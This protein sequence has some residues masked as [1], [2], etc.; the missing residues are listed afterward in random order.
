MPEETKGKPEARLPERNS[1]ILAA[2]SKLKFVL[3]AKGEL[4][5]LG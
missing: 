5:I 3:N 2:G 4:E 1:E